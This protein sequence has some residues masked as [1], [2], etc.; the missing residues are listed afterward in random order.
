VE[1][2]PKISGAQPRKPTRPSAAAKSQRNAQTEDFRVWLRG[3]L[4]QDPRSLHAVEIEADIRGNA[5]GKFLRG[6]RGAVHGL[7]PLMLRRL[8]PVLM[9]G[10]VELLAR[11]GHLSDKPWSM[12]VLEAIAADPILDDEEK[13]ALIITYDR[14]ARGRGR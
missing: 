4:A 5:L 10:E 3:R 13:I 6:E 8:A 14:F 2:G 11:A 12:P 7:T 9:I 1:D